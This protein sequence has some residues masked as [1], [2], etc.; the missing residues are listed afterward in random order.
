MDWIQIEGLRVQAHVGVPLQ[1]R[2]QRQRLLI[3]L[4]LGMNLRSAGQQDEV[5]RTIDY[6]A[7]AL[8]VKQ[9]V[10]KESFCLVEAIAEQLAELI[11]KQF[12]PDLVRIRI[13]KFSVPG[14]ESVG[15]VLT[16]KRGPSKPRK[17]S[18]SPRR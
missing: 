4:S 12:H 15:V 6:A 18:K 14:A 8:A 10:K 16:R 11:L 17:K 7:V 2:R 13:R 5:Q 1:E 3:D 9:L